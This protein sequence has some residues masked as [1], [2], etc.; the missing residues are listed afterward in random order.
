MRVFILEDEALAA[1]RL[2][3][4]IQIA[5]PEA[6]IAGWEKTIRQGLLWLQQNEEPDLLFSDIELLDGNVFRLYEAHRVNCPVIFTTA[7][8]Q[9]LLQAFQVNGIAYLLKPYDLEQFKQAIAKYNRLFGT[10]GVPVITE[11]VL[12][13]L[14]QAFQPAFAQYKQRFTV[15]M[16]GGIYLLNTE[17]IQYFTAEDKVVLACT[18]EGKRYPISQTIAELEETLDPRRFFKINRGDILNIGAIRKIEPHL[19]DRLAVTVT[20]S[21]IFFVTSAARTAPFRKWLEEG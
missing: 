21:P 2:M 16:G 20:G 9:F 14:K 18:A 5:Y 12:M 11:A 8:D 13:Q 7:Y 4:F 19:N 10:P 3:E 15:R 17:D 1:Q 6:Q